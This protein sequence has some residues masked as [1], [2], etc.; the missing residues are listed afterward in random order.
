MNRD[1]AASGKWWTGT[2]VSAEK[3]A[4]PQTEYFSGGIH[5]AY[6]AP[7]TTAPVNRVT[8][9]QGAYG[10]EVDHSNRRLATET[11]ASFKTTELIAYVVAVVA[12][13]VTA[14]AVGTTSGHADYFRADKA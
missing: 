8:P 13:I 9:D 5:M 7:T 10:A 1:L 4:E 11:K 12:V 2:Y 3:T 6:N 14:A